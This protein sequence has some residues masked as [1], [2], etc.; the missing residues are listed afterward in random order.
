M[1]LEEKI[2]KIKDSLKNK[3]VLIA[4]SG[5]SDSTLV[6]KIA[7]EVSK[8]VFAVTIDNGVLP[9]ECISNAREI[10]RE[11]GINHI[12]IKEDFLDDKSFRSNLHNR[13]YI[14]KNKMYSQLEKEALKLGLDNI[15]DGTNISDLL[16]DRPGIMVTF[17]NE[18]LSPL[19]LAGMTSEDV[20]KA[21]KLIKQD[22]SRST[23][24]LATRIP[25][26]QEITMKKINRINYAE[27]LIRNLTQN[28]TVRVRDDDDNATIEVGELGKILDVNKIDHIK[29]ELKAVGFKR[30]KL[31]IDGY[32][33]YKKDIVIYKPCKD[34]ANKI[35]FETQLPYQIDIKKTCESLYEIAELKCSVEMGII[36]M[37]L[38]KHNITIFKKG[39]IVARK[40]V[41]QDD[42][43]ELLITILPYIRRII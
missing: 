12:V 30:I 5:G 35:M 23:T 10:A 1:K 31:D 4:F 42:A 9:S 22:Y 20:L 24:C 19:L 36:M 18:I 6:A 38:N 27:S 37:E 39:K 26:G 41:D 14:C 8:E 13:C 25:K 7:S 21:L 11:I 29:S 32:D 16:E 15:V 40:V 34:E 2:E 28:E 3:K 17:D 43:E 33:E